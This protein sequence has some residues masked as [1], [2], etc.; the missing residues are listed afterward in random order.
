MLV[1]TRRRVRR[2]AAR[3]LPPPSTWHLTMPGV[4]RL[5]ELRW[6]ARIRRARV[7]TP[8]STWPRSPT[9]AAGAPTSRSRSG[10]PSAAAARLQALLHPSDQRAQ[11]RWDYH[12]V[13]C[14]ACGFLFR[15]PGIRPER[16]GDLYSSG[17]VRQVPGGEYGRSGIEPLPGDDGAVR[18][19]VR[20]RRGPPP[21]RLRL[22]S[23]PL[24]RARAR[25][26][27]RVLGVDLAADAI[28][29][30]RQQAERR[31]RLP[32][33]AARRSRRSRPAASTSSRCGRC[34][35]TSPSRSRT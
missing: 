24:P 27:L 31:A 33:R 11:P 15:H 12:V 2:V 14:A 4:D 13:R 34:S 10:A 28:E 5:L 7:M 30:A 20:V 19:A 35:P 17:Q 9:R 21:A 18:L 32:R 23:R 16:L 25:A 8:S 29:A 6:A 1:R 22:R 3:L 26:R